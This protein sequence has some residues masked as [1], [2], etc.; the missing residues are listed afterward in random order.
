MTVPIKIT[1]M[2]DMYPIDIHGYVPPY[3]D[4][5]GATPLN[6]TVVA[7]LKVGAGGHPAS[8]LA[9]PAWSSAAPASDTNLLSARPLFGVPPPPPTHSLYLEIVFGPDDGNVNRAY[10]NGITSPHAMDVPL[11][12]L[13][14]QLD[15]VAPSSST[16]GLPGLADAINHTDAGVYYM[17]HGAVVDVL[18]NNTDGGEHPIHFHGHT[19]WIIS[20]SRCA[21]ADCV[22]RRGDSHAR[23]WTVGCGRFVVCKT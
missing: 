11:P 8:H 18:I 3:E 19:F 21:S 4:G 15:G 7:W 9:L 16:A 12:L 22:A 5:T 6:T 14:A 23:H 2:E 20:T 1:A 10:F 17:P 13:Y